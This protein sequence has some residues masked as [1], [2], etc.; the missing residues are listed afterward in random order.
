MGQYAVQKIKNIK[1]TA[2]MESL[3]SLVSFVSEWAR[4][5]GM[6]PERVNEIQV[7]LEEAFVNICKYAYAGRQGDVEV[8]CFSESD[9]TVI[10]II[11]SGIPFDI[12]AQALPD[13][14]ADIPE[15]KIGGLGWL[16]IKSFMD[17]VV[18]RREN[19]KN[20]LRLTSLL[21]KQETPCCHSGAC[22]EQS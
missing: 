17:M 1:L 16:L 20:I 13:I 19:G 11:D 21:Q 12:T 18:Y 7:V 3:G 15:R 8:N 22:P 2:D 14:T 4:D 10:E 5:Q 6:A 9:S